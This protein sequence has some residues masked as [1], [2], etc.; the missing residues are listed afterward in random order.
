MYFNMPNTDYLHRVHCEDFPV[1]NLGQGTFY[2]VMRSVEWFDESLQPTT[3]PAKVHDFAM[4][5]QRRINHQLVQIVE[6]L[7]V[8]GLLPPVQFIGTYDNRVSL[9]ISP[10]LN[11]ETDSVEVHHYV[12]KITKICRQLMDKHTTVTI[13]TFDRTPAWPKHPSELAGI[14]PAGAERVSTYLKNI[15]NLWLLGFKDFTPTPKQD[16]Y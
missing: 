11:A 16:Y 12:E 7:Y 6:T 10:K 4:I 8:K 2:S 15:D 5:W 9:L 14:I 1:G 13:G 3:P